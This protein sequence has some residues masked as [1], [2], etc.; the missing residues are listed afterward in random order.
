MRNRIVLLLMILAS[1][2]S[3]VHAINCPS[4]TSIVIEVGVADNFAPPMEPVFPDANLARF[5]ATIWNVPLRYLDDMTVNKSMGHT[6]Q[7][8]A[9]PIIA[10]ELET[11]VRSLGDIPGNDRISLE[12]N[13]GFFNGESEVSR[14]TTTLANLTQ[15]GWYEG[16][17]ATLILDLGNLP[18]DLYGRTSVLA[19]MI[20]GN[21]DIEIQDDTAVDYIVLRLCT[22]CAVAVESKTWG[23]IKALYK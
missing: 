16:E 10:A 11:R 23:S 19:Y 21:L 18:V 4:G 8:E 12:L 5:I 13:D 1:A 6:F 7:W 14:W 3:D 15:T 22:S 20:D 17:E 9:C 2:S